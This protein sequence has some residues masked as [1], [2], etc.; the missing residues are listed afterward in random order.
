LVEEHLRPETLRR[1]GLLDPAAVGTLRGV[2]EKGDPSDYRLA[3]KIYSLL[4][5]SL[6][7]DQ[8]VR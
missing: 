4:I 1:Q 7:H 3:N 2:W 5:L 6:W 8:Y